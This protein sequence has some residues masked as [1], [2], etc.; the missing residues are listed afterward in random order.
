MITFTKVQLRNFLS[1]A[2]TEFRL[3]VPGPVLVTGANRD[4]G[5]ASSNGSGKSAL[6]EAL[7]WGL[8]GQTLRGLA[9]REVVRGYPNSVSEGCSV[10]VSFRI[11]DDFSYEVRRF[12]DDKKRGNALEFYS[13]EG[14]NLASK[15]KRETQGKIESVLGADFKLFVQSVVLGQDSLVFAQATD[16]EKKRILE[17]ITGL[18]EF[19]LY[20]EET[21]KRKVGLEKKQ[22]ELQTAIVFEERDIQGCETEITRL[23]RESRQFESQKMLT[24]ANLEKEKLSTKPSLERVALVEGEI[25][26]LEAEEKRILAGE[27]TVRQ[28]T[29]TR[30]ELQSQL[31]LIDRDVQRVQRAVDEV[32]RELENTTGVCPTCKRPYDEE[33]VRVT[34]EEFNRKLVALGKEFGAASAQ[35]KEIRIRLST[36]D[37]EL[38]VANRSVT[39][40]AVVQG[41]LKVFR[42]NLAQFQE[43]NFEVRTL[44]ARLEEVR[45]RENPTEVALSMNRVRIGNS[46]KKIDKLRVELEA[47]SSEMRYVDFWVTGFGKRGV[48]SLV[49]DRAASYLTLRAAR[50]SQSLTDGEIEIIFQTQR[51][52]QGGGLA[53]DF[54]VRGLNRFGAD[55]YRGNSVGERQRVD[56]CIALALQDYARSR[57]GAGIS[58]FVCDEA[59]ANLDAE[60]SE[61]MFR[62]LSDLA[63]DGRPVFYVTHSPQAQD[64][65]PTSLRVVKE[66][67]VSR[68]EK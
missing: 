15:D 46:K 39:H 66:G 12:Q 47:L 19:D 8:Y 5:S 26:K 22:G 48:R 56:V 20:L 17:V 67:G 60:G 53:E 62:L 42:A 58:L 52:R 3:D 28:L 4:S 21:K 33:S 24:L 43:L 36:L 68:V 50:Y 57:T 59:A 13:A 49:L 61:R 2:S 29:S 1:Y 55:V 32:K 27:E 18:G 11:G 9:A 40:K 6:F 45:K 14:G 35:Q 7:V 31:A 41:Q 54:Q 38:E 44:D 30:R 37:R 64:L 25:T 10:S 23:E 63:Q 65:F 34:R 16:A 51:E